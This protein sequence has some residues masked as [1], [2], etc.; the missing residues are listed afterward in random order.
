MNGRSFRIAARIGMALLLFAVTGTAWADRIHMKDG[1]VLEGKVIEEKEGRVRLKMKLGTIWLEKSRIARIEKTPSPEETYR[2]RR[3]GLSPDDGPGWLELG[4]FC[5]KHDFQVEAEDCFRAALKADPN[6]AEARAALDRIVAK[7]A[8]ALLLVSEGPD[9]VRRNI[10]RLLQ[11]GKP[12][13]E[14][15]TEALVDRDRAVRGLLKNP[16]SIQ[17]RLREVFRRLRD[18]T[19]NNI[20]NERYYTL[21]NEKAK[22]RVEA[23]VMKLRALHA[24]PGAPASLALFPPLARWE[25]E[26]DRL[27]KSSAAFGL[28]EEKAGV[29]PR[30]NFAVLGERMRTEPFLDRLNRFRKK[31]GR[32]VR[33]NEEAAASLALSK[34]EAGGVKTINDYRELMGL[35]RLRID[36]CLLKAARGHCRAMVEK[37]FFSHQSPLPGLKTPYARIRVAGYDYQVAGENIARKEGGLTPEEALIAWIRSP[38]HHRALLHPDFEDLGLGVQGIYWTLNLGRKRKTD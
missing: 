20:R 3:R 34:L 28:E 4:R 18:R 5:L 12:G 23:N 31:N 19:L 35:K 37:G 13:R 21:K 2:K 8:V 15:V 38:D 24:D 32:V 6:L 30:V 26:T 22:G 9:D 36:P 10:Q 17:A 25:V 16:A 29:R 1:R 33:D 14:A 11:L 7:H 27:L